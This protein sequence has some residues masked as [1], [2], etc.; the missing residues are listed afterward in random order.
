MHRFGVH[1]I[2]TP[3]LQMSYLCSKLVIPGETC[4]C[5]NSMCTVTVCPVIPVY[6]YFNLLSFVL[7]LKVEL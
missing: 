6:S 5:T 7:F 1:R 3:V 2:G 4:L